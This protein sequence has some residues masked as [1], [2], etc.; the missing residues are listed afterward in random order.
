VEHL[1]SLRAAARLGSKRGSFFMVN[2]RPSLGLAD[3][4][5][6]L[7]RNGIEATVCE[8][9]FSTGTVTVHAHSTVD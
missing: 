6:G 8:L 7:R 5:A 2:D 3:L 9:D 4:Q 1:L